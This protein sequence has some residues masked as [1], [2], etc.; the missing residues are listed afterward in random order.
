MA[1]SPILSLDPNLDLPTA[2]AQIAQA[3]SAQRQG[4]EQFGTSQ[5]A[6]I[7]NIYGNLKEDLQQGATAVQSVYGNAAKN[8][9]GTY[10]RAGL[11][12]QT[13][14]ASNMGAIG[15]FAN[16]LGMDPRALAEVQGGLAKQA[17]TFDLRNRQSSV[18]SQTN[19]H[20]L[21]AGMSAVAQL[22]I[23]A[24]AQAEAQGRSDLSKK[25]QTELQRIASSASELKSGFTTIK[26]NQ[27]AQAAMDAQSNLTK[28]QLE[29][30]RASRAGSGG[31]GGGGESGGMSPS[32]MRAQQRFLW[33]VED[34]YAT[35]P[36][37]Q[38]YSANAELASRVGK[39]ASPNTIMH[40]QA[41]AS[42]GNPMGYVAKLNEKSLKKEGVSK[43]ALTK[44][45]SGLK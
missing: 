41:A 33:D 17:Q 1:K 10:E 2:I 23:Q 39:Y 7:Q 34:R 38:L 9:E 12:G 21:G 27:A 14:A 18:Q 30:E 3:E 44:W 29:L 20:Q 11:G 15:E 42:S 35:D 25:I 40:F 31:S 8:V 43:T 4:L 45:V 22:G 32:E 19:L 6:N 36:N 28:I 24:A 13:A 5:D 37:D 16:R 26:A